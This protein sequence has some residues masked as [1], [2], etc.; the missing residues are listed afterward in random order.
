MDRRRPLVGRCQL[1]HLLSLVTALRL[2]TRKRLLNT[3][4]ISSLLLAAVVLWQGAVFEVPSPEIAEPVSPTFGLEDTAG[5]TSQVVVDTSDPRWRRLLQRP[6]YDPPPPPKKIV[7]KIVRPIT[8]QLM[9][10]ILEPENSQAFV[11][12]SSG[13]VKLRRVGDQLTD[14]PLDGEVLKI[15][16]NEIVIKREDGEF[17]VG[18][19][20]ND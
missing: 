15:T 6:L 1:H 3:L 17:T 19:K 18:V 9:G 14:D 12:L 8:V 16:A 7:K 5:D 20:K 4:A 10:T 13:S 11:K 2:R